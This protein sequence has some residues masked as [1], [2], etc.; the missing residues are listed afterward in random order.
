MKEQLQERFKNLEDRTINSILYI[1]SKTNVQV[2][3]I[4]YITYNN[5]TYK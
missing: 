5:K 2:R 4:D 3:D 1:L